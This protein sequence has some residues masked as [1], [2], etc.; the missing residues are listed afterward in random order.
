M[1]KNFFFGGA[2]A[3]SARSIADLAG[4]ALNTVITLRPC[5]DGAFAVVVHAGL[6]LHIHS[7]Y[8]Q[9]ADVHAAHLVV[10]SASSA[11]ALTIVLTYNGVSYVTENEN[12]PGI[13]LF[14]TPMPK[15]TIYTLAAGFV[16]Q[17]RQL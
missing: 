7:T 6:T 12:V 9:H 15:I 3:Q 17:L 16:F 11:L 5:A 4:V 1:R 13:V 10:L 2:T 14:D 8:V